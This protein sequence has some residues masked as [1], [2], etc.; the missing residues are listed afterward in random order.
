AAFDPTL[1]NDLARTG[2]LHLLAIS[3]THL[4][5]LAAFLAIAFRI[6]P[7]N[8]RAT[9]A[10]VVA[11]LLLYTLVVGDQPSVL[12]SFA[13]A[14]ALGLSTFLGRRRDPANALALALL[15]VLVLDP[16]SLFEPG[17][18]LSFVAVAAL[19]W[20]V[21]PIQAAL[22]KRLPAADP[23]DPI[24]RRLARGGLRALL[25]SAGA[26]AAC[27]ITTAPILLW[28][29]HMISPAT[30]P[31]N[32]L[33]LPIVGV[34]MG[35]GFCFLA[36]DL[37][38]LPGPGLLA[39]LLAFL[40]EAFEWLVRAGA[41][42]PF[43][44]VFVPGPGPAAWILGLAGA[45]A[46][47][48][49]IWRGRTLRPAVL[50]TLLACAALCG[51]SPLSGPS[52]ARLLV[53]DAGEGHCAL[54]ETG[55]GASILFDAGSVSMDDASS[56]AIAPAL[57]D[58]G[59]RRVDLLVLSSAPPNRANAIEGLAG[60]IPVRS[61]LVSS[62]LALEPAGAAL[63][64]RLDRLGIPVL[65]ASAGDEVVRIPGARLRILSPAPR[66]AP[67]PDAPL[68]VSATCAGKTILFGGEA[69]DGRLAGIP[70]RDLACDVLILPRGGRGLA[71]PDTLLEAARPRLAAASNPERLVS[72]AVRTALARA[73]VPLWTTGFDGAL[74]LEWPARGGAGSIE[75][76]AS[77]RT[78][79]F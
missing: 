75:G 59:V 48:W 24:F 21:P 66:G 30:I 63:L 29:F 45:A 72:N 22:N 27:S 10:G 60:R 2:T 32:L 8:R 12:R 56:F 5:M 3:G 67:G 1:R 13:M 14:A 18:Q 74:L 46:I 76:Y 23:S 43:A 25:L 50:G 52:A 57:F 16:S 31:M 53:L 7:L 15:T 41:K 35:A 77:G 40:A 20:G 39:P 38:G 9:L 44:A 58:R 37:C 65:E 69:R 17:M 62:R 4:A 34:M 70:A 36:L 61:C 64:I 6:A 49:R 42:V 47:A 78:A 73:R 55:R 11:L 33:A 71:A 68:V 19:L 51:V 26:S 28:H 79:G 54:L